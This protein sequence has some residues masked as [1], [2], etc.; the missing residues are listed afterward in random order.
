MIT[1]W[2]NTQYYFSVI[3]V[4]LKEKVRVLPESWSPGLNAT[5]QVV[6]AGFSGKGSE[7]YIHH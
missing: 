3:C 6:R 4:S 2:V 5:S 1:V 7:V